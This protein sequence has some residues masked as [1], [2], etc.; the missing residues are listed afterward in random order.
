MILRTK[1]FIYL[2]VIVHIKEIFYI[3]LMNLVESNMKLS[4]SRILYFFFP[5]I[6]N[7]HFISYQTFTYYHSS[8]LRNQKNELVFAAKIF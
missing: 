1:Y 3:I 7:C 5:N 8:F 6:F 2:C 4:F